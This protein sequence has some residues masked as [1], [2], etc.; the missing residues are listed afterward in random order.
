MVIA[1]PYQPAMTLPPFLKQ[2]DT[3]AL[4]APARA[5]DPTEVQETI[6][7]LQ[8]EGFKVIYSHALFSRHHQFAGDDALRTAD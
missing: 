6:S 3:I 1:T 2:G 4:A 5:I 8:E 7:W